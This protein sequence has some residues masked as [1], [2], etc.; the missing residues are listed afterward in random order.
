M[1]QQI[2]V[3]IFVTNTQV[4]RSVAL[5]GWARTAVLESV[6]YQFLFRMTK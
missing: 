3:V 6:S 1:T 5:A 4:R 2:Q